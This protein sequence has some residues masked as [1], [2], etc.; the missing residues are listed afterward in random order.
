MTGAGEEQTCRRV[1]LIQM[2]LATAL[3]FGS[4][5][6][7]AL[8]RSSSTSIV[9]SPTFGHS[10][11]LSSS[12]ALGSRPSAPPRRYSQRHRHSDS[13]AAVIPSSRETVSRSS[14]LSNRITA[15]AFRRAVKRP[16]SSFFRFDIDTSVGILTPNR[17][18]QSI[19]QRGTRF[20]EGRVTCPV[21]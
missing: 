20:F 17:V 3:C 21:S 4:T 1:L 7:V 9:S 14:P 15:S 11:R 18:S 10:V 2:T 16:L 6:G 13:V 19:V 8:C 12:A 5:V